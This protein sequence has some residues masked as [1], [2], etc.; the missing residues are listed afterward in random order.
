MSHLPTLLVQFSQ[1]GSIRVGLFHGNI[2]KP[3]LLIGLSSNVAHVLILVKSD[4]R[5]DRKSVV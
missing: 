2:V 5:A 1:S 4:G 3:E